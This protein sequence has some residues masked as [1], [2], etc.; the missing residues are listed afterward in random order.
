MTGGVLE[1]TEV[2]GEQ[3]A[4]N[5]QPGMSGHRWFAMANDIVMALPERTVLRRLRRRV[6]GLAT[7]RV[8]EI[9]CGTGGNLPYYERADSVVATDPDP[10]M[11]RRARKR[12][13]RLARPLEL[14][15]CPAEALPFPDASFDTVVSFLTLCTVKDPAK[16]LAEVR[17]VLRPGGTLR[18]LEHVR[19][20]RH[21][22]WNV[23][24]LLGPAW[25]FLSAGC[26][27]D[28]ATATTIRE[29]G[30]EITE[31]SRGSEPITPLIV[32]VARPAN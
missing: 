18:F 22:H 24:R 25:R 19:A 21:V 10:Y 4:A 30:F 31:L 7:G 27:L 26:N 14:R 12:A 11:L 9:G 17:R 13:G 32:G 15:Q 8:L 1:R 23:Q 2:T 28:R 29:T 20:E 16:A 5:A 6:A 3:A